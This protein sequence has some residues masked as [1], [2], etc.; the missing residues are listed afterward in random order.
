VSDDRRRWTNED[1]L[2]FIEPNPLENDPDHSYGII[3]DTYDYDDKLYTLT[4]DAE[5]SK[6]LI[7]RIIV[8]GF[9]VENPDVEQVFSDA[10][11]ELKEANLHKTKFDHDYVTEAKVEVKANQA[12]VIINNI[13]IPKPLRNLMFTSSKAGKVLHIQT[14]ITKRLAR[15]MHLDTKVVDDFLLSILKKNPNNRVPKTY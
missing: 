9:Q 2:E 12:H 1:G 11:A 3:K 5:I 7:N 13:K 15:K 10:F 14:V 6:L 4:Y 8:K